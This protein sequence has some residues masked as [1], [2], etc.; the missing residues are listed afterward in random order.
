[1][2]SRGKE[3]AA[4]AKELVEAQ[5]EHDDRQM[6][7]TAFKQ[8]SESHQ[9]TDPSSQQKARSRPVKMQGEAKGQSQ[10]GPLQLPLRN[11]PSSPTSNDSGPSPKRSKNSRRSLR[12]SDLPP[13]SECEDVQSQEASPWEYYSESSVAERRP[14]TQTDGNRPTKSSQRS[15]KGSASDS[16]DSQRTQSSQAKVH[17]DDL[18]WEFDDEQLLM[19]T[20]AK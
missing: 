9:P 16:H 14:L 2:Q 20:Q 3:R 1:V 12:V 19:S 18:E 8:G 13:F 11:S 5:E 17:L 15:S 7:I 10:R 6:N 4:I